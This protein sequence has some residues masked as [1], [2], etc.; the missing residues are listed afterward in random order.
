MSLFLIHQKSFVIILSEFNFWKYFIFFVGYSFLQWFQVWN[1]GS[2]LWKAFE[3][4]RPQGRDAYLN[5]SRLP[6]GVCEMTFFL[7]KIFFNSIEPKIHPSWSKIAVSL[8]LFNF[9]KGKISQISIFKKVLMLHIFHVLSRSKLASISLTLVL[10]GR[11]LTKLI[12]LKWLCFLSSSFSVPQTLLI[13]KRWTHTVFPL[14]GSREQQFI[15][16]DPGVSSA[17]S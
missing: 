9:W 17:D 15:I 10:T 4:W 8:Y 2:F 16:K 12:K 7:P 14:L 11:S 1:N 6:F 3:I 5:E 13:V